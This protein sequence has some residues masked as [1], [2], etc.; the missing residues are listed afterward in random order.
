V[1]SHLSRPLSPS[2]RTS[3]PLAGQTD[4]L[5]PQRID[6]EA[7]FRPRSRRTIDSV[8]PQARPSRSLPPAGGSTAHYE[9]SLSIDP[10][11]DQLAA[12]YYPRT[13]QI[14]GEFEEEQDLPMGNTSL[15]L[16]TGNFTHPLVRRAPYLYDDDDLRQELAQ[17]VE[18]PMV[19]RSSRFE[20]SGQDDDYDAYK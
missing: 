12:S 16:T 5:Q 9:S 1:P 11:T 13:G 8:P 20:T 6:E 14:A 17:Q 19:R 2:R 18:E 15:D 7:K 4:R 3:R 10:H